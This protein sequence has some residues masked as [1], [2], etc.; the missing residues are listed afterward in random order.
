M[1]ATTTLSASCDRT[2]A[3]TRSLLG[4]GVLAGPLYVAVTLA[5]GLT[6]EG[7]DFTRHQ[8]SL[9]ANGDLGWIHV[10]NLLVAGLATLAAAVGMRR[11]L[12]SGPG[13]TWGPRLVGVYG[14]SLPAAAVFRADPALG[15]PVG[16]PDGQGAVSAAGILHMTAGA[17]GFSCLIAACF[18]VARRYA[19]TGTAVYSRVTGVVF[20]VSFAAVMVGAGAVWANLAFTAGVLAAWAWLAVLSLRLYRNA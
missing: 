3:V 13:A 4:Y 20:A 6:R 11:A 19:G 10:V 2:T 7:F 5:Q 8:W 12:S 9:L 18:V 17:V 14:A 15:F 16:T 1:T